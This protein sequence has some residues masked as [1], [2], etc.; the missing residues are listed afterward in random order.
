M[1]FVLRRNFE[2]FMK[3][4]YTKYINPDLISKFFPKSN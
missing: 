2:N 3:S 1:S 4:M